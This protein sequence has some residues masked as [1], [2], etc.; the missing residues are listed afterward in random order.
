MGV[1]HCRQP[2]SSQFPKGAHHVK[3][4]AGLPGLIEVQ[5]V[6]YDNVEKIVRS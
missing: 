5:I 1:A 2:R 6:P 3:N 4:H